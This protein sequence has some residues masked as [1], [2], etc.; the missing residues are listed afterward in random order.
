MTM[1]NVTTI[2]LWYFCYRY[3]MDVFVDPERNRGWGDES[4]FRIGG[5]MN[6]M[7]YGVTH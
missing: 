6:V 1:A 4:G 2:W 7:R 5:V 3:F